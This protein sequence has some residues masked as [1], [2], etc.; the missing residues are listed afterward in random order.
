MFFSTVYYSYKMVIPYFIFFL[1]STVLRRQILAR[2][3]PNLDH[4]D[5][6]NFRIKRQQEINARRVF[7]EL[8]TYCVF[9]FVVLSIS[10]IHTDQRSFI[11]KNNVN[12]MLVQDSV[13]YNKFAKVR[14]FLKMS[15]IYKNVRSIDCLEFTPYL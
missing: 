7:V 5:L 4:Q 3:E 9:A 15:Q 11:L 2:H 14:F 12:N 8:L 10:Y 6:E 13:T 1:S